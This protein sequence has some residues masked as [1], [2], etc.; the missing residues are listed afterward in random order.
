MVDYRFV[1]LAPMDENWGWLSD[2]VFSADGEP[3]T[4]TNFEQWGNMLRDGCG[5]TPADVLRFLDD[6][7]LALLLETQHRALAHPRLRTLPIGVKPAKVG[8]WVTQHSVI[9]GGR[10]GSFTGQAGQ[11]ECAT[12]VCR[13][14]QNTLTANPARLR[15]CCAACSTTSR[16][17]S[18]SKRRAAGRQRANARACC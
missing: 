11:G 3:R 13:T 16:S 12:G 4:A 17:R 6:P 2:R 7:R 5:S 18:S 1:L 8:D 10:L 9:Q 14:S 15:C